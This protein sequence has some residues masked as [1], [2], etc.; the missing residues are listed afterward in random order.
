MVLTVSAPV[1]AAL[2]A[3]RPVVALESTIIAHGFPRPDNRDVAEALEA[4][5]RDGGAE[6][7]TIAVIAGTVHVGL[8]TGQLDLIAERDDIAKCSLRDLA[9]VCATGGHGATTVS[10]TMRL[11][12]RAGIA[13]FAT[14]GIGGVHPGAGKSYD[15]SADLAEL[16]RTPVAV[17][18]AGAKSIL[19][20]PATL[21]MLE[22]LGVPVVGYG[23]DTFPAFHSRDSGLPLSHRADTPEEM[24]GLIRAQT[25]LGLDA[26]I[27][28]AN[29]P[30]ADVAMTREELDALVDQAQDKARADGV[31][32][33]ALTPY[34]LAALNDLSG[35]RTR[36]INKALAIANAT[37][38]ARI[39]AALCKGTD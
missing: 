39:A 25:A 12:H 3:G 16:G 34:L 7:A 27:L 4:A 11:A 10:A 30:P 22:T 6:P 20:L 15:V 32:G 37:L 14:G 33:S 29:P 36:V 28:I 24:A 2:A 38:G 23:C 17:V 21:E 19:D 35:G 5:V 18:C 9:A 8:S 26:G 1:R 31:A 13:V